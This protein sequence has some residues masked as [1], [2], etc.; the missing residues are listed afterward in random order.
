MEEKSNIILTCTH[1]FCEKCIREWN[2]SSQTCP[3]CRK[4]S[5]DND[6]FVLTEKPDYYNLQDE[7]SKSLF[8]IAETTTTTTTT[9]NRRKKRSNVTACTTGSRFNGTLQNT[10]VNRIDEYDDIEDSDD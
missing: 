10:N 2:I 6:C 5:A 1:N 9:T 7:M 3:I 8:Q 4:R